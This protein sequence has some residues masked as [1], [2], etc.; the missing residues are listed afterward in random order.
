MKRKLTALLVLFMLIFT[1]IPPETAE[2]ASKIKLN[3]TQTTIY[4][5]TTETL[6]ITGTTKTVAWS[7]S[8]KNVAVVSTKGKVTPKKAGTATITAKVSDKKYTCKV[9]VK[10]PYLNAT[11]KTLEVGK[12][13]TLKLTGAEV[14]SFKSG[15][16]SVATVSKTGK[17][18]AK[19]A[20]TA[21][22]TVKDSKG[23]TYTCTVTV[24]KHEHTY[25]S[26]KVTTKA[27]CGKAGVKTYTCTGCKQTKTE[28]IKATGKHTYNSGKVT[29]K[30]T[31]GK[32]GV[33][34]YTCTG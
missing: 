9:T 6:K 4:M 23:R 15:K 10:D 8:N 21:K 27:T 18:T 30:A 26:G 14:T 16:T 5:G 3:K 33:K 32:A 12:T 28:S 25:D 13:Y 22:I 7:S 29:T 11:K 24:K 1:L 2:A 31:C 34:T 17:I 19:K 20:G